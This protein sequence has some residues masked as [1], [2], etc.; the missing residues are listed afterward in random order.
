MNLEEWVALIPGLPCLTG[1][2]EIQ[3][4]NKV[5]SNHLRVDLNMVEGLTTLHTNNATDHFW[6]ND[7]V[8]Q[9]GLH[10]VR[11]LTSE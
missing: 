2:Y 1:L 4:S 7:H 5:V 6:D 8:P 3:N 10:Q 11:L 9:V